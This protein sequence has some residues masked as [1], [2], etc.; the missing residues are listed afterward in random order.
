MPEYKK[1]RRYQERGQIKMVSE[2]MLVNDRDIRVSVDNVPH[3][4]GE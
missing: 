3:P 2:K 4:V 1:D